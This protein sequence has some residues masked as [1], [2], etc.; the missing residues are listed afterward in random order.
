MSLENTPRR[1]IFPYYHCDTQDNPFIPSINLITI[2]DFTGEEISKYHY[3]KY[4]L[5]LFFVVF[6]SRLPYKKIKL[7]WL[8]V[9]EWGIFYDTKDAMK[10]IL[11]LLCPADHVHMFSFGK[12]SSS[13]FFSCWIIMF[14]RSPRFLIGLNY[15]HA[16]SNCH[17][18]S[19]Q[20]ASRALW[21]EH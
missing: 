4:F 16:N 19:K 5:S 15:N 2:Y 1:K 7:I 13:L 14:Y 18:E 12:T 17:S 20:L 8:L 9:K 3:I 11:S 10:Y 6:S 21:V